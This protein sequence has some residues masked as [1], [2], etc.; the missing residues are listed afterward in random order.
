M[1]DVM[2]RSKR[3]SVVKKCFVHWRNDPQQGN[4]TSANGR[5]LLLMPQNTLTARKIVEES[6]LYD[7]LKEAFYVHAIWANLGN[8]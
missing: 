8:L 5:K 1:V 3:I 6:G 4:S 2:C 7:E